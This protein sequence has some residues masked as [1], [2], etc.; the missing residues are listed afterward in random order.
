M[1]ETISSRSWHA[2]LIAI[3]ALSLAACVGLDL[4]YFSNTTISA[5][6]DR[7][8]RSTAELLAQGHFRVGDDVA[9]EMP[10]T[11]LFFAA[12][13]S[14][15]N[16]SPLTAVRM[17]NAGL[18]ALQSVLLGLLAARVFHDRLA[19]LIAA[20]I[21]GFYPYLLFTQ[22]LALS[23]TPFTVLLVA[24]FLALYVWKDCGGRIDWSLVVAAGLLTAATLTKATLTIMPPVLLAASAIG[25]H[26][27]SRLLCI[28]AVAAA[29]YAALM[30]PWWVRNYVLLGEFVPFSTSSTR[31]LYMGNSPFNPRVGTYGPDLPENWSMHQGVLLEAIPG[32]LNRYHA[33]RDAALRYITDDPVDFFRRA[34]IKL[35]VFWNIV[36]NAPAFQNWIYRLVGAA[37]FGPV[38]ALSLL[39]LIQIQHRGRLVD[40]LPFLITIGYFTALYTITIPSIRYRLPI[41]PLL[42]VLAA[43]PAAALIRKVRDRP[44]TAA[45]AP[46]TV[47]R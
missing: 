7:F 32:E 9:W 44:R 35:V 36:P 22:G 38:F 42:I 17:A 27:W 46:E 25:A 34:A 4:S 16:T 11:A 1:V 6:E 14:L 30:S 26:S 10:G 29:V 43:S 3:G 21:G 33:F 2:G 13:T 5:D 37:S 45:E 23:E 18:A 31:N 47:C 8:L 12:A 15:I 20:A 40:L 28:F 19:G 41:E 24:S 39:C